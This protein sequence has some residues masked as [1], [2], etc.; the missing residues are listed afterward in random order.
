M[1]ENLTFNLQVDQSKAVSAINDFFEIFDKGA[2]QAK[3]K[4]NTAFNQTLQTE[5]K[6]E[7]K[8]GKL[9]AKEVQNL[10]Q[11]SSRLA[12]AYKAVN[13]ELGK[14]PNQLKKQQ[15]VLKTLL[16]D[17]QKFKTGTRQ[18]TAEWQ[19]LTGR[20][21]QVSTELGK[22]KTSGGGLEAIGAKFIGMQ[23]A[24][25]LATTGVIQLMAKIGEMVQTAFR[26]ETL[27]LQL[28][29]FVGSSE[30][31]EKAFSQFL[32][33][34]A[35]S[36]LN[37]EQVA[38]AGKIMMAFGMTT[39]DAVKTTKQLALVSAATGGDINLLA[40]NMGQI[41][42]QGR[43]YTRDLTQFAIQG[44]PIWEQ[45]SVATGKNVGEL[46]E[47]AREGQITGTEVSAALE[48]M[49]RKGTAFF[50]IGQRMQETFTGRF[51]AIEAAMQ[52]L[53][54]EFI[55]SFNL[56]DQSFGGIVSGSMKLFADGVNLIA[57]N[58]DS[59]LLAV[60]ALVVGLTAFAAVMVVL[61][62]GA[63]AAGISAIVLAVK[64]WAA[65]QATLNIAQAFFAGLTG[66]WV[67]I[68]A[69]VA[70]AGVA[71][72]VLGS[73]MNE[74]K[75]ETLELQA[76]IAN[77][78][79]ATG[80]LSEKAQ[81]Y[82]NKIGQS[83]AVEEYK[84][85]QAEVKRITEELGVVVEKLEAQ[86]QKRIE[87]FKEEQANIKQ[88]IQDEKD[89]I[90]QAKIGMEAA[91]QAV[92]EKYETE[93]QH[94]D[95][96]LSKIREKYAEEIG[97]LRDKTPAEKA[98]YELQKQQIAA[99]L[100]AGGLDR[101]EELSLKA[102]LERMQANEKIQ[103]L[104]VQK[105]EAEKKETKSLLDL[106]TERKI[107][108]GEIDRKFGDI[109]T[110][111]K[112]EARNQKTRL[113][114]SQVE[115]EAFT[116]EIDNSIKTA[117]GLTRQIDATAGA[118][119]ATQTTVVKLTG[120]LATATTQANR[121]ARAI[122]NANAARSS[123]SNGTSGTS[124]TPGTPG[125]PLT[126]NFAGGPIAAGT[127]SWVNELG[128]EAFLSASGKLSMINDRGGKWTAPSDGTVIPAHL[129]RKLDI[130]NGGVN[131]NKT[132]AASLSAARGGTNMGRMVKAL[133]GAL[134]GDTVTN[135]V[136]IQSANTNKTASHVMVELA[137]LK[138]LRYN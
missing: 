98:L 25:N 126:T 36:P 93:K 27:S 122:R 11:E 125:T 46:K 112:E 48:L 100:E 47:M 109:I 108:L 5:I 74:S 61:N 94:I 57:T 56:I 71:V 20:I 31:A 119:R 86:K 38:S 129:T 3:S 65:A 19:K 30:G 128:K 41:V 123:G 34:A 120:D 58:M 117:K 49:T 40:R 51:A 88:L 75:N 66:N 2:A 16:G 102:R 130:P 99:K 59:L 90:E 80:E 26:M 104:M 7:F 84:E 107:K 95:E 64:G 9:V 134:G 44:I 8:N 63:I 87:M 4:L 67:A 15:A 42:A 21:K 37:L 137:K 83:K 13:G 23:T 89:K 29:A 78:G 138:R 124:G 127:T 136:T 114:E 24:A 82:A 39:K 132:G 76:E 43:A 69:G 35:N 14:T 10:K 121:L 28:E 135:N 72:A 62:W 54:K 12:T 50:E 17:T 60:S 68:A 6:V 92:N 52:N 73:K 70:A 53:S 22:M 97:H 18:L 133:V 33:I 103:A 32:N 85:Q 105:K 111:S 79:E 116:K 118:V 131:I 77:A 81:E 91:K 55:E 45:L 113:K 96:T 115:Q 101:E 106:E 110:K 1:A